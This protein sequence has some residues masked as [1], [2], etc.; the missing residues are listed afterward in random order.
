MNAGLTPAQAMSR[1]NGEDRL[2]EFFIVT[3][4][5]KLRSSPEE[6]VSEVNLEG[7]ILQLTGGLDPATILVITRSPEE[8]ETVARIACESEKELQ[9]QIRDQLR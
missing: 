4:P 1:F 8:A 6:M 5:G 9:A 2:G 7:F 3:R